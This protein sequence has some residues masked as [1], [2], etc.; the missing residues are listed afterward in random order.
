MSTQRTSVGSAVTRGNL[1][2]L[3]EDSMFS[4]PSSL[5]PE[6]GSVEPQRSIENEAERDEVGESHIQRLERPGDNADLGLQD[7]LDEMLASTSVITPQARGVVEHEAEMRKVELFL[8]DE[9]IGRAKAAVRRSRT[10]T[11]AL[12]SGMMFQAIIRAVDALGLDVN[13]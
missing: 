11:N 4:G 2:G 8:P 7:T 5:R 6:P 12:G 9:V 10:R 1:L 13:T 3:G